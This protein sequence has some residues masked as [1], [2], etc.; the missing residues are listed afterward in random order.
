MNG[1][2]SSKVVSLGARLFGGALSSDVLADA[3]R[4]L[5]IGSLACLGAFAV[6]LVGHLLLVQLGWSHLHP[7]HVTA[8]LI[9]AAVACGFYL[10]AGVQ[11]LSA[12]SLLN[13]GLL[14]QWQLCFS[15]SNMEL[16]G[17]D[18]RDPHDFGVSIV[19]IIVVLAPILVPAPPW[20][21]LLIALLCALSG[22]LAYSRLTGSDYPQTLRAYFNLYAVSG[23]AAL[24][25]LAPAYV[26]RRMREELQEAQA[27]GSYQLVTRLGK[28]GMGEVWSAKHRLLARPAAIKLIGRDLGNGN[29]PTDPVMLKRFEQEVQATAL[30]SNPHTT[31]IYDYGMAADGTFYYVME[32]LQGGD[33]ASFAAEHGPLGPARTVFIL[34]QVLDSLEEAHAAGLVHRDVKPENIYLCRLGLRGDW[35]KVLDFGLALL[36]KVPAE[37]RLTM[38]E[39]VQGTPAFM[40]PE[41]A[42]QKE[43]DGRADLYS[44]ACLGYWLLTGKA[45]FDAQNAVEHVIHHASSAPPRLSARGAPDVGAELESLL[46][47]CLEKQPELRPASAAEF[48]HRLLQCPLRDCWTQADADRWWSAREA[49]I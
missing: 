11:Q 19:C 35:V 22:P 46:L 16:R 1:S 34:C 3:R 33:L 48:R 10:L 32:L 17:P 20:K 4:R 39:T 8:T 21:T 49:A 30:L 45:V 47:A 38:S 23:V 40:S 31:T 14:L 27:F 41:Q 26:L 9:G 6:V 36:T 18:P 29:A 2:A 12:E 43:V 42:L 7:I 44:V 5:R 13:L 15:M 37:A 28:G 25:S 24:L